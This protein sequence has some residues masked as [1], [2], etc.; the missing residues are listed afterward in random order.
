MVAAWT[1]FIPIHN[2][3]TLSKV[4]GDTAIAPLPGGE[5]PYATGLA[6]TFIWINPY[7]KDPGLAANS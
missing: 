2:N 4:A 7:A 6:P 3:A 5:F 1:S